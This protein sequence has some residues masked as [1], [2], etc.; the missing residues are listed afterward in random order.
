MITSSKVGY[1]RNWF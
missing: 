1:I